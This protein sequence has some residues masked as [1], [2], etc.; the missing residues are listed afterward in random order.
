MK[1]KELKLFKAKVIDTTTDD[2]LLS[3]HRGDLIV[4]H[5]SLKEAIEFVWVAFNQAMEVTDKAQNTVYNPWPQSK[6]VEWSEEELSD[7][8]KKDWDGKEPAILSMDCTAG[9][10]EHCNEDDEGSVFFHRKVWENLKSRDDKQRESKPMKTND[11]FEKLFNYV[12]RLP[13]ECY[14]PQA[15]SENSLCKRCETLGKPQHSWVG[16][17]KKDAFTY[18]EF[19]QS[20]DIT[21]R[22]I[23]LYCFG[24]FGIAEHVC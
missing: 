20:N 18:A 12:K 15:S 11:S 3:S 1:K 5:Y 17:R 23:N 22:N 24:A 6:L 4:R 9:W 13:C 8:Y 19:V 21:Q 16:V 2:W 14:I 7:L 10:C